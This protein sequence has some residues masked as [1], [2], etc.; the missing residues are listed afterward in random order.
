MV[1]LVTEEARIGYDSDRE[2]WQ[3]TRQGRI[4]G[5]GQAIVPT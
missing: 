4:I 2:E 1:R 3:K 5:R